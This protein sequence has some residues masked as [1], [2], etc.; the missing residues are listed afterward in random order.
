[1]ERLTSG[2]VTVEVP[3]TSA[4]LGPGFDVLAMALQLYNVVTVEVVG[5]AA[6]VGSP[7]TPRITI[8]GNGRDTLAR[9]HRNL[10]YRSACAL[11]GQARVPVPAFA[12][13]LTNRIPV[14]RG[15][16]S[17]A[18]AIVGG[19]V[20]AN[21]LLGE[22]YAREELLACAL[23]LEPHPDNLAAALYGGVAI[24]VAREGALPIVRTFPPAPGLRVVLLIPQGSSSTAYARTILRPD[25]SRADA[26]FNMAR[27]ALLVHA[28]AAGD[29]EALGTAMEDRLHQPQRGGLFPALP[30]LIAAGRAAGAHGAAL[31]GAGSTILALAS[32]DRADAVA[33]AML[34]E[35]ERFK[36]GAH[37]VI[38][39]IAL[40]GASASGPGG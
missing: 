36:L 20:A 13:H 37:T 11:F 27:T 12:L 26:V 33:A 2:S 23:A 25:V 39:D 28:L 38:T 29:A 22:P 21:M 31:S 40:R 14:G 10:V 4:N 3:A 8:D 30:A 16:G 6:R 17:S 35:S 19:L 9:D 34:E 1:M 15:L 7:P 18:A 32:P 5:P 24:A